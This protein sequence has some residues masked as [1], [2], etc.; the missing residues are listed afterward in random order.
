MAPV[1]TGV[2]AER[3]TTAP[4][5]L[6]SRDR[7]N[8]RSGKGKQSFAQ[9]TFHLSVLLSGSLLPP[10]GLWATLLFCTAKGLPASPPVLPN[11]PGKTSGG[12]TEHKCTCKN[13]PAIT[14]AHELGGSGN[15]W[16]RLSNF[17]IPKVVSLCFPSISFPGTWFWQAASP[18]ESAVSFKVSPGWYA[19]EANPHATKNE[20]PRVKSMSH[21]P[22]TS[23]T[24]SGHSCVL[25]KHI[26]WSV[27][28]S[29]AV[30]LR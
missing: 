25:A 17:L 7:G 26:S 24:L 3:Q 12:Q 10:A 9:A 1:I 18:V 14:A 30:G 28:I 16:P 2:F 19:V 11:K 15:R 8:E 4:T 20:K 13:C 6:P 29:K 23:V 5:S 21:A 22:N 27:S